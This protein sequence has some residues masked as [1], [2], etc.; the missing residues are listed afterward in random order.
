M[1]WFVLWLFCGVISA[2]IASSRGRSGCGWL[3][4]GLMVGPFGF[5]VALLPKIVDEEKEHKNLSKCPFCAEYIKPEAVK[6][7][8]CGSEI[9]VTSRTILSTAQATNGKSSDLAT[10]IGFMGLAIL[11]TIIA[12]AI[13]NV[14][15]SYIR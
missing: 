12:I 13:F 15:V 2:M 3:L 11:L 10:K 7:R 1:E 5:A 8:F 6:C 14:I 9:P 4:L